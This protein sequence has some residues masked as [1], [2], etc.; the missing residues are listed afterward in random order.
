MENKVF[1]NDNLPKTYFSFA[2]PVVFSMII[3]LIYNLADTYFIAATGNTDLVAGVS[4]CA[5]V[6]TVLM[7][8]GNVFAQGGCS[9]I[10]RLLGQQ[11]HSAVRH[12]SAFC[13]YISLL[14]GIVVGIAML[15][16]RTPI[17]YALGTNADTCL[18]ALPYYTCL[19]VGA[20][21]VVVS[22]IYT[23]LLRA[24]GMSKEAFIGTVSGAV[25]NIILD[26]IFILAL[27]WNAGGA[28]FAT[29][30]GYLCSDLY[31]FAVF[32]K[33]SQ[34]L[35]V[36]L[37]ETGIPLKYVKQ[38]LGIG[39]PAALT[40]IMQSISVIL[41]NHFL[42]PYG[43]IQVATMGI[44]LKVN[45]IALFVLI[46]LAFGGQPLFGYYYG[47][48]DKKRLAELYRFCITFISIVALI[49]T[50]FVYIAAPQLLRCFATDPQMITD[51][52]LMLRL[53][54]VSSVFAGF[55][56][57]NT[58]VTQS[59]G[60]IT[61]SFLLSISRQ[62]VVF[63]IVLLIAAKTSGYYGVLASQAIADIITAVLAG[64][65]IYLQKDLFS[66]C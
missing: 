49:L 22:Y 5:P 30:L 21:F 4:L 17:L 26:P 7:A 59:A 55:V 56:L 9:L 6:L 20:P 25:I 52:T 14:T 66:C 47:S 50:L 31:C 36:L 24:E 62:G 32:K 34:H 2:L 57:L 46:G 37:K 11:D 10:S 3:T 33:K 27:G 60:K 58:I 40:N 28:A 44:V 23:N 38:I 1:I 15:I 43:N 16:F 12:V 64:M 13:V 54:V 41:I 51:G 35:S 61:A 29:I 65:L 18:H 63:L 8:L 48:D 19:T 45:S 42:L 53:Q 39:I